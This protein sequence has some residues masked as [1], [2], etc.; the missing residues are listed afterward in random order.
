MTRWDWEGSLPALQAMTAS[1]ANSGSV[2][3]QARMARASP[4]EMRNCAASAP[5][6]MTNADRRMLG[7]VQSA[8][9]T[10]DFAIIGA[11]ERGHIVFDDH[12]RPESVVPTS[13][14][15]HPRSHGRDRDRRSKGGGGCHRRGLEA[16]RVR[17][18]FGRS[19]A[20]ERNGGPLHQTLRSTEPDED[21]PRRPGPVRAS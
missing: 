4:W 6:A 9:R 3:S 7:N 8:E 11:P 16:D 2:C 19:A 20:E 13:P 14:R 5:Q 15:G 10:E 18:A 12:K 21:L 1:T 17:G